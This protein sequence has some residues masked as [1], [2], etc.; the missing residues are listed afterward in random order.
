MVI[1]AKVRAGCTTVPAGVVNGGMPANP[2]SP[3]AFDPWQVS[4][5]VLNAMACGLFPAPGMAKPFNPTSGLSAPK[6]IAAAYCQK[7]VLPTDVVF[8]VLVSG[9]L[10]A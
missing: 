4:S 2:A 6:P 10:I 9:S 3:R 7:F 1:P 8:K 5:L